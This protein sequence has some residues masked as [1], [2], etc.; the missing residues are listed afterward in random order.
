MAGIEAAAVL[1]LDLGD[2]LLLALDADDGDE[3]GVDEV[4]LHVG[5]EGVELPLD[6]L[7]R[8]VGE[9]VNGDGRSRVILGPAVGGGRRH[10]RL[11]VLVE[12]LLDVAP[13][14]PGAHG[15]IVEAFDL[16]AADDGDAAAAAGAERGEGDER[17]EGGNRAMKK[18]GGH[19]RTPGAGAG[20]A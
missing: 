11:Q 16:R 6:V 3:V 14:H 9:R 15:L 2:H 18:R 12:G 19:V 5:E 17:E 13:V 8:L 1:L 20:G 10:H 7:A 4:R